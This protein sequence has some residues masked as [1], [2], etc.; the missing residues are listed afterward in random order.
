MVTLDSAVIEY[1]SMQFVVDEDKG[2]CYYRSINGDV[3]AVP[4]E[5]EEGLP[6]VEKRH[7]FQVHEPYLQNTVHK[8]LDTY[9]FFQNY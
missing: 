7:R 2:R 4:L 8:V 5:I 6:N 1:K 9:L 3:F